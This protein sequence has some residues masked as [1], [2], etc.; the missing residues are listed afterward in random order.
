MKN[1]KTSLHARGGSLAAALFLLIL[2][3]ALQAAPPMTRQDFVK[4]IHRGLPKEKVLK[5]LGKP[6]EE[7]SK[8]AA[9][10][11]EL[12]YRDKVVGPQ[13]NRLEAVTIIIYDEYQ[14]VH[15]VRWADGTVV[16]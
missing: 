13:T 8:K 3:A 14:A 15:S 5:A 12:T 9:G 10:V 6:N 16:E 4:T 1:I 2:P 11:T 7:T